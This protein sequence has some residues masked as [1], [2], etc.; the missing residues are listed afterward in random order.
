MELGE[1]F[2]R[3]DLDKVKLGPKWANVELSIQSADQDAAWELYVEM[4]TRIV[5]QPL[6]YNVGD[7]KTA[8]DSVY[9]LFPITRE[10]LRRH[11]RSTIKFSMIAIPVLNQ[12]VRPFTAKW[13]R[14]SLAG[15]FDD[16]AK[17]QEFRKELV[18]LQEDLR[19]YNRMLARDRRRR[20][21][22]R[23]GTGR[24]RV[25][26]SQAPRHRT[27]VSYHHGNDQQYKDWL[28]AEM[29]GDIVDRSVEDG[30]I[31]DDLK[32]EAIWE[33]IRDEHIADA[34][35]VI[36]L[37]G[38]DTWSRKYVDWEIGSALNK[39]RNN[40]RCGVLGI[41]LPS[42]PDYGR[43]PYDPN[44]LPP[45]L[46]ANV[47]GDDPYVRLYDWPGD[48]RLS[49]IRDWVHTAFVRR[50]GPRPDNFSKRFKINRD[51]STRVPEEEGVTLVEGFLLGVVGIV[52][53]IF[54]AKAVD[55]YVLEPIRAKS[56]TPTHPFPNT[57]PSR[58][59]RRRRW[60]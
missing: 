18:G 22:D 36:V 44:L 2:R 8:L 12:V 6:P 32:T 27:F 34:T 3:F 39:S 1:W 26:M 28:V 46:V 30:D 43:K 29:A 21:P 25:D 9:S 50:D 33:K 52:T 17:R 31:D 60:R 7:D 16:D 24:G 57:L 10:I 38:R 35:V 42:H 14:E 47:Q 49:V 40:S 45:R 23:L 15:A 41:V 19:S 55:R 48:G 5:T 4:L 56:A 59:R 54:I 51:P 58:Y 13:H 53:G 20:R 11:G 37:I